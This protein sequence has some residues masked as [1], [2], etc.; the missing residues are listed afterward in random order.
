MNVFRLPSYVPY[1]P[2]PGII[3]LG[4]PYDPL[5]ALLP[6]WAS[7]MKPMCY[8]TVTRVAARRFVPTGV[9]LVD[10]V[11]P[12]IRRRNTPG[13]VQYR[14]R[15]RVAVQTQA[16]NVP[17]PIPRLKPRAFPNPFTRMVRS[18]V[19]ALGPAEFIPIKS[20]VRRHYAPS[21][22]HI[23]RRAIPFQLFVPVQGARKAWVAPPYV[24]V[25][26]RAY[27]IQ[28]PCVL[29]TRSRVRPS[30][31]YY[32]NRSRTV[33]VSVIGPPI[34]LN[35]VR[36][37][38]TEV[39]YRKPQRTVPFNTPSAPFPVHAVQQFVPVAFYRRSM[40]FI[41]GARQDI[42]V[43]VVRKRAV[44]QQSHAVFRHTSVIAGPV[45][46]V[47]APFFLRRRPQAMQT[48]YPIKPRPQVISTQA[49]VVVNR[50]KQVPPSFLMKRVRS[51]F[52]VTV[53]TVTVAPIFMRKQARTA[54]YYPVIRKAAV[55][56][57]QA[58]LVVNRKR[59][60]PPV[61]WPRKARTPFY[62]NVNVAVPTPF[63]FFRHLP[64][65]YAIQYPRKYPV[66]AVAL[67]P[68]NVQNVI[69]SSKRTVR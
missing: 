13:A 29:V 49:V 31:T 59:F 43:P 56:A 54:S 48:Y 14:D 3:L 35:R 26:T 60:A 5:P 52:Y 68:P 64:R 40:R 67:P 69:V 38:A 22:P 18:H 58:V 30:Q 28:P 47:V 20:P 45:T 16:V 17:I 10:N 12:A 6:S 33:P 8:N 62:V 63:P 39:V 57:T 23:I 37:R 9:Q 51:P 61:V 25:R 66:A 65:G 36:Q 2:R 53:N 34:F 32:A 50:H 7:R 42:V 44:V 19:L 11:I 21:T 41:P 1:E 27:P 15:F 24:R 55:I 46:T 4:S